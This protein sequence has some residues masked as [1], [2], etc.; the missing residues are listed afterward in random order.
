MAAPPQDLMKVHEIGERVAESIRQF[1]DQKENR[2]LVES[3]RR[4]GVAM[5]APSE[6][7]REARRGPFKTRLRHHGVIDGYPREEIR[8][9]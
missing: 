7:R 3:L 5:R 1:F 8:R 4:A 2:R 6:R 9:I